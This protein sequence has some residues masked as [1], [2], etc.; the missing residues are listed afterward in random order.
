MSAPQGD[1][2]MIVP[3]AEAVARVVLS[4]YAHIGFQDRGI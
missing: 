4:M 1:R 2:Y 3:R